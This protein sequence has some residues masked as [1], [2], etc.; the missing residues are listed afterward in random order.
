MVLKPD[1]Y[2]SPLS[3]PELAICGVNEACISV[4]LRDKIEGRTLAMF[5]CSVSDVVPSS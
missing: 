5:T 2:T 3:A 1:E 4:F